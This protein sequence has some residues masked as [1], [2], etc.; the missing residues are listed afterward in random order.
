MCNTHY[1]AA[2]GLS[3]AQQLRQL[4]DIRCDPSRLILAEQLGCVQGLRKMGEPDKPFSAHS[5]SRS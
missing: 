4:G 5:A 1:K 2:R 3:L